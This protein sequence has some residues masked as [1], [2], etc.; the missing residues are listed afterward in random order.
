MK[1]MNKNKKTNKINNKNLFLSPY[2]LFFKT[3]KS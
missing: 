2:A 1:K 3:F